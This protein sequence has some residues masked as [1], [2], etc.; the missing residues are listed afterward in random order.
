MTNKVQR[1]PN[2]RSYTQEEMN[3]FYHAVSV[4][5]EAGTKRMEKIRK[6]MTI[7]QFMETFKNDDYK[8]DIKPFDYTTLYGAFLYTDDIEIYQ[9]C[10]FL[11][12]RIVGNVLGDYTYDDDLIY[13]ILNT[14][15]NVTIIVLSA[16]DVDLDSIDKVKEYAESKGKI[17]F[18]YGADSK[19]EFLNKVN[20]NRSE[21]KNYC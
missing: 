20:I 15:D 4:C 11:G 8:G 1:R 14:E 6:I 18:V 13:N 10:V 2:R 9:L 19:L 7:K 16:N 12:I 3:K 17:V 21:N 5:S